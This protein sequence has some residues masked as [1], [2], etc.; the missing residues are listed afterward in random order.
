[1]DHIV[2]LPDGSAC[3]HQQETQWKEESR[4]LY[5]PTRSLSF[6]R[7]LAPVSSPPHI[8]LSLQVPGS[9]PSPHSFQAGMGKSSPLVTIPKILHSSLWFSYFLPTPL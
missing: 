1:M 8:L 4:D 7:V 6:D 2:G 5:L 9:I 3:W